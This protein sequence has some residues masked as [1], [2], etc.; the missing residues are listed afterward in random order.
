MKGALIDDLEIQNLRG[1][2]L[3]MMLQNTIA[4]KKQERH[5]IKAYAPVLVSII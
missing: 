1:E 4:K 5:L 3:S 2:R